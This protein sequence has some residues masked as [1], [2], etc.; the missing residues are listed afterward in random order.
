M[1]NPR[2]AREMEKMVGA[3]RDR[4]IKYPVYK[5]VD[6]GIELIVAPNQEYRVKD[7]H[8]RCNNPRC[9]TFQKGRGARYVKK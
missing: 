7:G 2:Q 4:H 1:P 6:C 9:P 3:L 8:I 5:C